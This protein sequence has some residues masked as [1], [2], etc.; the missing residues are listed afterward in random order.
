M[1]VAKFHALTRDRL[2]TPVRESLLDAATA[3][4]GA[5]TRGRLARAVAE[6]SRALQS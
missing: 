4:D 2:P 6:A 3:L 1:I 5:P